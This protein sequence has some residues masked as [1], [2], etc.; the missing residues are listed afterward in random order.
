VRVVEARH[1]H[2]ATELDDLGLWSAQGH[3]LALVTDR[4]DP[5]TRYRERLGLGPRGVDGPD[6]AAAEDTGG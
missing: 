5:V 6:A 3:D 4:D 2:P 1:E